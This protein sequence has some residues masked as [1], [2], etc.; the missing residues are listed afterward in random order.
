MVDRARLRR[1]AVTVLAV[2][3]V[4]VCYYATAWLGLRQ[5]LVHGQVTPLWPPTGIA[6]AA[7]LVFGV[8][9][10]PGIALG[11]LAVNSTIDPSPLSILLLIAAGNTVA[12]LCSCLL[13]RR[14]DF[15][16]DLDRLRDALALVFLGALT[17]MLISASA[18]SGALV[19]SGAVP[20]AKF[21]PTWS[22]WWTGDAM[23]VMVVTPFLLAARRA[24]WPRDAGPARWIEATALVAATLAATLLATDTIPSLLFLVFPFL[25][26]AAFRFE[27]AGAACCA[28]GVS[29]FAI[30]AARRMTGP[31]AQHGLVTNMTIL[32]AFNGATALT[33]LLLGAAVTERNRT[34]REIRRLC[35]HL[36]EKVARQDL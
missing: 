18:G 26:W 27:R 13:L 21:W 36:S 35:A 6:M 22:V 17:G 10:W 4:A 11:S 12:P 16:N 23:G 28:L 32:Q 19:L 1:W 5:Q 33:A 2:L 24:R 29:T 20:A 25:V 9:I 31:F 34:Y 8:R 3:G 30:L 7:L 15:H 14:V